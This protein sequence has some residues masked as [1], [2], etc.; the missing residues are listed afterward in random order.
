MLDQDRL[1]FVF[2][3]E[4]IEILYIYSS[5]LETKNFVYKYIHVHTGL[6]IHYNHGHVLFGLAFFMAY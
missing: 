1:K 4:N 2:T 5:L 3:C 6:Y